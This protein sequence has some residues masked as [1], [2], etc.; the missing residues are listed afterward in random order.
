MATTTATKITKKQKFEML[1]ALVE[2]NDMLIEFIDHEIELLERKSS[3]VDTKKSAEHEKIMGYIKSVLY[4]AGAAMKC[5]DITQ[6]V[7]EKYNET[8]Q[9]QKIS[10]MLKKMVDES[11]EVTKSTE[12]K[13]TFF[14]L[15][16]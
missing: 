9:S 14:A 2:D 4:E 13:E 1:R 15:A 10:A 16:D 3:K 12:K 8:Y 5:G 6:R 11:G 7:N